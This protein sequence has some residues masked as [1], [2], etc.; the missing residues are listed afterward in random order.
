MNN[1]SLLGLTDS[2]GQAKE[3]VLRASRNNI[4]IINGE[5]SKITLGFN[6]N[7]QQQQR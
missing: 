5:E 2:N 7:Q 1:N 6:E 3:Q 4:N